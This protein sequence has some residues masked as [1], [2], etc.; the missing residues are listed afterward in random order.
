MARRGYVFAIFLQPLATVKAMFE[1]YRANHVDRGLPGGGGMAYMPLVYTADSEREA[2]AGAE[3]LNWYL[4]AA[5]APPHFRDPPGYLPIAAKAQAMRASDAGLTKAIRTR[6][7]DYLLEEGI[8]I[9]GTPDSVVKQIRTYYDKVGG[10]DHL[11]MMQQ[12]G[13]LD[14]ARTAR[15]MTLF[16]KEVYPRIRDLPRTRAREASA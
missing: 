9:A 3:A 4:T 12:A 11:L 5:K 8:L 7:I 13:H 14:H 2:R 1:V 10:F 16:A 6:G 15:S